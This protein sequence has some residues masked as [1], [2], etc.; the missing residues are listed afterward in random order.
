MKRKEN[1]AG[2][3]NSP[4]FSK[5]RKG[6]KNSLRRLDESDEIPDEPKTPS[7]ADTSPISSS[8]SPSPSTSVPVL[9]I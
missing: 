4:A 2:A 5:N 1:D 7:Q 8:P 6:T 9:S 3:S